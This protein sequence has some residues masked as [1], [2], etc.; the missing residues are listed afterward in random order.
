MTGQFIKVL[1]KS[2][3]IALIF[4]DISDNSKEEASAETR[5]KRRGNKA[6]ISSVD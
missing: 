6:A 4:F 2:S 3:Y 1:D 5:E